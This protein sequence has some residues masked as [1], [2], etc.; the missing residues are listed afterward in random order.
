LES[1]EDICDDDN[2]IDDSVGVGRHPS[3]IVTTD[4]MHNY[5]LEHIGRL[6]SEA[7][8]DLVKILTIDL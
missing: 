5:I 3:G 4:Q 7:I 1:N 6:N 2:G 8:V